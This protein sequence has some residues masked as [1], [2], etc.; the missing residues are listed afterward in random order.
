MGEADCC[1]E[2]KKRFRWVIQYPYFFSDCYISSPSFS[3]D[4]CGF[5][6][7]NLDFVSKK[8][9]DGVYG[10]SIYLQKHEWH[11]EPGDVLLDIVINVTDLNID[12]ICVHN[13]I[14]FSGREKIFEKNFSKDSS[15][16]IKKR[17]I[18]SM[19]TAKDSET[20]IIVEV[21]ITQHIVS[22]E[23]V[24]LWA[25]NLGDLE[26]LSSDIGGILH[27]RNFKIGRAHV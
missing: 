27:N 11:S 22:E 14:K 17:E 19:I 20:N 8:E 23:I 18:S 24:D 5:T 3:I 15:E 25:C 21:N 12:E 13:D 26:S 4:C 7:Y 6:R 2:R 16:S 9:P 10:V 1:K